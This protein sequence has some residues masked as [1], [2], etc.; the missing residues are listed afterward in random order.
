[1]SLP[2]SGEVNGELAAAI[3]AGLPLPP[4]LTSAGE[5]KEAAP[6]DLLWLQVFIPQDRHT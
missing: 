6:R 4:A 3:D 2:A 5:A 1:L